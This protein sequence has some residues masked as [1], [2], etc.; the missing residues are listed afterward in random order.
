MSESKK[1]KQINPENS[2]ISFE[3]KIN[4]A[5]NSLEK[6]IQKFTTSAENKI[7]NFDEEKFEKDLGK[8]FIKIGKGVVVFAA[9]TIPMIARKVKK[10]LE[11]DT[12]GTL[13]PF[14]ILIVILLITVGIACILNR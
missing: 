4:S 3:Q 2:T 1:D 13:A 5:Y 7:N 14:V 8:F 12:W 10:F 9:K 6:S 11:S